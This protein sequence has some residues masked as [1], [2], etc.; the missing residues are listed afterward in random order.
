MSYRKIAGKLGKV[1]KFDK[2]IKQAK[3]AKQAS[4][5]LDKHLRGA[6]KVVGRAKKVHK[7][8]KQ[9]H[10]MASPRNS[11]HQNAQNKP[12]NKKLML[13]I[14]GVLQKVE[15]ALRRFHRHRRDLE[16]DEELSRRDFDSDVEELFEQEYDDF[17]AE[18]DDLD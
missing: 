4:Q 15:G 5:K 16:D 2:A 1:K 18:R 12:A 10:Q 11:A 17:L 9:V 6:K 13:K 8:A 14:N 3:Q 7:V